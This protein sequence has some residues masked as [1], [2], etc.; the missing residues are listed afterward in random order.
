M[1]ILP[2][3]L[4]WVKAPMRFSKRMLRTVISSV[5]IIA[6]VGPVATVSQAE[7][8]DAPA[9]DVFL[10]GIESDASEVEEFFNDASRIEEIFDLAD[11]EPLMATD[12]ITPKQPAKL[13]NKLSGKFSAKISPNVLADKPIL[14]NDS[15]ANPSAQ[16]N[17]AHLQQASEILRNGVYVPPTRGRFEFAGGRWMFVPNDPTSAV[18]VRETEVDTSTLDN[19]FRSASALRDLRT[20][21]QTLVELVPSNPLRNGDSDREKLLGRLKNEK[22]VA[23]MSN[24]RLTK[25][26]VADNLMLQRVVDSI[27]LD[28]FKGQWLVSGLSLIHI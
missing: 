6:L 24:L 2:L 14:K 19:T 20:R 10:F 3:L 17:K 9:P 4:F 13:Q 25:M 21:T 26:V 22:D 18:V 8:A 28:H 27:R 5:F 23:V 11:Q 7:Q 16:P 15:E 1:L 12:A